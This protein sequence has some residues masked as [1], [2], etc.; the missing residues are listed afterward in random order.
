MALP[1]EILERMVTE[2]DLFAA[3]QAPDPAAAD[4]PSVSPTLSA[5][6]ADILSI[7]QHHQLTS[8]WFLKLKHIE[9]EHVI[10]WFS[11]LKE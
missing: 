9:S 2:D 4:N 11:R 3:F 7:H 6:S 1:T 5:A 10:L 8:R